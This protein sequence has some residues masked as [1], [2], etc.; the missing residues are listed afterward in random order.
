MK[1]INTIGKE[2]ETLI[3]EVWALYAHNDRCER[4]GGG[5]VI[6]LNHGDQRSL[7]KQQ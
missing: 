6:S 1:G 7:R 4:Y 5:R 2:I 3:C